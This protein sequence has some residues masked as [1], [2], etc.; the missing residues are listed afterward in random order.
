MASDA[1]ARQR[2][3]LASINVVPWQASSRPAMPARRRSG[4]LAGRT[5]G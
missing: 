5:L 1:E 4:L 3:A 2:D